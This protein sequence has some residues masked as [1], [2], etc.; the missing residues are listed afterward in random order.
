MTKDELEGLT[1]K[2][3][4]VLASYYEIELKSNAKKGEIVDIILKEHPEAKVQVFGSVPPTEMSVRVR[5]IYE[6]NLKKE[7]ENG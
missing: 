6:A 1:V 5:R 4:K 7:K 3:L 2:Q